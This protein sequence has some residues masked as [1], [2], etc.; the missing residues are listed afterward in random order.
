MASEVVSH[1]AVSG[2]KLLSHRI[3]KSFSEVIKNDCPQLFTE[4]AERISQP[5][6]VSS[7][8]DFCN[9][10]KADYQKFLNQLPELKESGV[11]GSGFPVCEKMEVTIDQL[12]SLSPSTGSGQFQKGRDPIEKCGMFNLTCVVRHSGLV[13]KARVSQQFRIVN[14]VPG[15]VARFSLFV[16]NTPYPDSYNAMGVDFD[17]GVDLTYSHPPAGG[18]VFSGPLVILNGTDTETITSAVAFRDRDVDQKHLRD[19][20]WIYLGASG[21]TANAP[22]YLKIPNGFSQTTGGLFMF[23]P[24]SA[25]T[26]QLLAPAGIEP[27]TDFKRSEDI[28][29]HNYYL[30]SK[31]H[32]YYTKEEDNPLGVGAKNLWPGL[33]TGTEFVPSDRFLSASTWLY[34]FG[35]MRQSSRTLIIGPVLAGYLKYFFIKG[36][37]VGGSEYRGLFSSMK[38]DVFAT[39]KAENKE[40]LDFCYFWS[41]ILEPPI[42]GAEFFL[43]DYNSFRKLMPFN[44]LPSRSEGVAFR[45]V[46]F[47]MIFDFMKYNR[48]RYP[49]VETGP[50]L[51]QNDYFGD[52]FHVPMAQAMQSNP[53]KGVHP[54]GDFGIFFEDSGQYNPNV[55]PDNCYF[56]GDMGQFTV[57]ASGLVSNRITNIIDLSRCVSADE[58]NEKIEKALFKELDKDGETVNEPRKSGIFLVKRRREATRQFDDAL[59]LSSRKVFLS[60]PLIVIT[61]RGSLNIGHDIVADLKDGAPEVLCSL[62]VANGD[63]YLSGNGVQRTV[64]A[65]LIAVGSGCGRLLK[66]A[67]M[68]AAP[69]S[70]EIFG[71]LAVSELGLYQDP[72]ADPR[73]DVGSTMMH[74]P[75]G[76]KI[77]YNP[78][79]NPSLPCYKEAYQLAMESISGTLTIQGG[80]E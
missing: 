1:L 71:G 34:P 20:G 51:A 30:G 60:A 14:M 44:S 65:F 17:G 49:D 16:K 64:H 7:Y 56:F 48:S 53:V 2:V 54:G 22:V 23:G 38:S 3:E 40:L 26:P 45:G 42:T 50:S 47:N 78:R 29:D 36:S 67:S 19:R 10:V 73:S 25:G 41:G 12:E 63:I 58:E 55:Y 52:Q 9:E 18:K 76:G 13:R 27:G 66:P 35:T 80:L 39:K 72:S 79:F 37:G 28:V 77:I 5:I 69:D 57:A 62:A 24:P 15:P 21:P 70:F 8:S 61:D 74:F 6:D 33:T 11:V 46:S 31:Y 68:A 43:N 75:A 32:G 59:L 4:K